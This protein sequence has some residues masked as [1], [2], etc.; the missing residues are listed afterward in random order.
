M[1]LRMM[2]IIM[3]TVLT[4]VT[5]PTLAGA[6]QN[7]GDIVGDVMTWFE[8][9][10]GIKETQKAALRHARIDQTRTQG[11]ERRVRWSHLAPQTLEGRLQIDRGAEGRTVTREEI[12]TNFVF[13]GLQTTHTNTGDGGWR[14]AL[15]ARWDL[16]RLVFD[17]E[18]L[19]VNAE[20]IRIIN[21]RAQILEAVTKAYF[22]RRKLQVRAL[23]LPPQ[24][25]IEVVE[26]SLEIK[27]LAAQLDMWTGGW[28]T[29]N[30]RDRGLRDQET[31]VPFVPSP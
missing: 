24:E 4:S 28:F 7:D 20:I 11:W 15:M 16:S 30:I 6:Q 18:E 31:I 23:L 19:E 10:P 1:K 2:V 3:M 5:A 14:G 12:D 8:Q 27:A 22:K 13:D 9:E 17:P 29:D 25:R 26:L 21:V